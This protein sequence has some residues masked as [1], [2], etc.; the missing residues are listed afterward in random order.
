[1]C[2][3]FYSYKLYNIYNIRVNDTVAMSTSSPIIAT[4]VNYI[5]TL[6]SD[7]FFLG[8]GNCFTYRDRQYTVYIL[9]PRHPN[10]C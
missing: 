3:W 9:Y 8:S 10:T 5:V 4:L 2:G 6:V 7:R 1:M